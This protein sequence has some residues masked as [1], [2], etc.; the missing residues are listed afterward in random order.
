M[1]ELKIVAEEEWNRIPQETIKDLLWSVPGVFRLLLGVDE[2]IV[3]PKLLLLSYVILSVVVFFSFK[4]YSR[5]QE[6]DSFIP[7]L[8][9]CKATV[10]NLFHYRGRTSLS[11]WK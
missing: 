9:Y 3:T 1:A 5:K 11:F 8:I 7:L 4:S 2:E 10:P 6:T